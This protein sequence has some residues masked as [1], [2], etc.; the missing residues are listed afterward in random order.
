M[1]RVTTHYNVYDVD[2]ECSMKEFGQRHIPGFRLEHGYGYFEFTKE[3]YF[4]PHK[5]KMLMHEVILYFNVINLRLTSCY[6][7]EICILVLVHN[8]FVPVVNTMKRLCQEISKF[9][10]QT[11]KIQTGCTFL[12]KANLHEESFLVVQNSYTVNIIPCKYN[13][14]QSHRSCEKHCKGC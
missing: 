9:Q 4:K 1:E 11:L 3:E 5:R 13:H 12:F 7:M 6:R 10:H 8:L 14:A 2:E